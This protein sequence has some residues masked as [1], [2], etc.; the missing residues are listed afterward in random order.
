MRKIETQMNAAIL[1]HKN[2]SLDNTRVE[3]DADKDVSSVYL[4]GNLIAEIGDDWMK[5]YDGGYQSATTKS[6][7]N[8]I[9]SAHCITGEG[10]FQRNF[11]WF[12]YKFVGQ[13]GSSPVFVE[14]EFTNG[15]ILA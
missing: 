5:L 1:N 7:I 11:K 2:W 15:M 8:A 3:Y 9:C 13:I 4:Y 12:V 10:I 14:K 6:R